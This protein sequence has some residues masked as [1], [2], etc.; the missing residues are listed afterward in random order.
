MHVLFVIGIAV[1]VISYVSVISVL[2]LTESLDEPGI[3]DDDASTSIVDR[4]RCTRECETYDGENAD[5]FFYEC[6][7]L[8]EPPED[9]CFLA[10]NHTEECLTRLSTNSAIVS[11]TI[12]SNTTCTP[13]AAQTVASQIVSVAANNVAN[14]VVLVNATCE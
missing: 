4:R 11:F 5:C 12:E 3:D 8:G 2:T 14:S 1:L 6:E 9:I 13:A 10:L 7:A